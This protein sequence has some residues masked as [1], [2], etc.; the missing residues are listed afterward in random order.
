MSSPA[1][2]IAFDNAPRFLIFLLVQLVALTTPLLRKESP[3]TSP[4]EFDS[5]SRT[6]RALAR[7]R[8]EIGHGPLLGRPLHGDKRGD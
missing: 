3:A 8:A 7:E 1:V 5:E 2:K 6:G 4:A